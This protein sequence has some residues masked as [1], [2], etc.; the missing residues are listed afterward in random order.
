MSEA[1]HEPKQP[2]RKAHGRWTA[3]ALAAVAGVAIGGGAYAWRA[4]QD[5]PAASQVTSLGQAG[6]GGPFQLVDQN[7]QSVDE[8]ALRGKWTAVFFGYT[9]CPDFC[10][11]TLQTLQ[12]ASEQLGEDA[13][14]LQ[15][16]LITVDPERDTPQA[17]NAYLEGYEFPGGVRGLTGTPEQVGAATKAWKV[18]HR[19]APAAG[20][21]AAHGGYLVDHT[22]VVYLTN[23]Q[24]QLV[25]VLAHEN[26]PAEAARQIRQAMDA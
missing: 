22:T 17:L 6:I 23:P 11:A 24:G 3:I 19:K 4:S 21:H 15:V 1:E 16:V 12:A 2:G 5:G 26:T 10:P 20:P 8:S 13:E 14:K 9:S 25:E 18:Y 7:G